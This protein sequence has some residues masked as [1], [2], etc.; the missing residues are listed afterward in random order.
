M[1]AACGIRAGRYE[2][3]LGAFGFT[4]EELN[5]VTADEVFRKVRHGAVHTGTM[6]NAAHR[7]TC[8][9]HMRY[10]Q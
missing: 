6:Q 9:V 5:A 7:T 3:P 4:V 10:T 8:G 2:D 1:P